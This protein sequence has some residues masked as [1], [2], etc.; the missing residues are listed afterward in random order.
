[1]IQ[2]NQNGTETATRRTNN[3]KMSDIEGNHLPA[4]LLNN[5]ASKETPSPRAANPE[6]AESNCKDS[7]SKLGRAGQWQESR[8]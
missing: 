2:D 3:P 4:Y 6:E 1:M 8:T 7:V 5:F